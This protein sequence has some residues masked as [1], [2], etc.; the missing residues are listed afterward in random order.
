MHECTVQLEATADVDIPPRIWADIESAAAKITQRS[1]L[2]GCVALRVVDAETIRR[3][4]AQ[5]RGVDSPTDVLS[6]PP[7]DDIMSMHAGDLALCWEVALAQAEA[8][9]NTIVQESVALITHGLLHLAG[10]DH[11][12]PDSGLEMD[13]LTQK[14]CNFAG[15]EVQTFGH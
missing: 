2:R 4:N 15:I 7:G 14:L 1:G 12:S 11:N 5:Y 9:G 8:N 3:L 13:E 6:F 10:Y